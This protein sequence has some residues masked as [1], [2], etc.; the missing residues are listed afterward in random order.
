MGSDD[1]DVFSD[2][3]GCDVD[4]MGLGFTTGEVILSV[5]FGASSSTSTVSLSAVSNEAGTFAPVNNNA[6]SSE[7]SE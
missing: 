6:S 2:P 1:I 4:G 3:E 7:E 5:S